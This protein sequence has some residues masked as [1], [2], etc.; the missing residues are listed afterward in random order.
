MLNTSCLVLQMY[1]FSLFYLLHE[2]NIQ[3]AFARTHIAHTQIGNSLIG[4]AV[5]HEMQ[6]EKW[7]LFTYQFPM[8]HG[9]P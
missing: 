3:K 7:K 6:W 4:E 1:S 5:E 9:V 2:E 8:G